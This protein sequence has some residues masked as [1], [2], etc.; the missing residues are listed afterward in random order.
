VEILEAKM[1]NLIITILFLSCLALTFWCVR[2][3]RNSVIKKEVV[4][5]VPNQ[6]QFQQIL[7]AIEPDRPIKVDYAIGPNSLTKWDRVCGN[8]YAAPYHTP[9]GAPKE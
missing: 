7:N 3:Y 4:V 9:S 6:G 2:L 5:L 8:T 1:K